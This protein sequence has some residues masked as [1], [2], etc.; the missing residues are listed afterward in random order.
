MKVARFVHGEEN[1]CRF[2]VH[3]HGRTLDTPAAYMV[4]SCQG[5]VAGVIL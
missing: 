1:D 4:N 3:N 2:D 5:I